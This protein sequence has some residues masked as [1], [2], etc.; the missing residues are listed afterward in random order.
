MLITH[1]LGLVAS[2]ADRVMV[3]YAGRVAEF[4]DTDD[5]YYHPRHAYT[6]ACSPAWPASISGGRIASSPSPAPRRA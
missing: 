2:H 4:A 3:M 1:D 6:S 5:I